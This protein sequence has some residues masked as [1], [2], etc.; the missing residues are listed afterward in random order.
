MYVAYVYQRERETK[1]Q[2]SRDKKRFKKRERQ[3][4]MYCITH[5]KNDKQSNHR[6]LAIGIP[7]EFDLIPLLRSAFGSVLYTLLPTWPPLSGSPERQVVLFPRRQLPWWHTS[8]GV[9]CPHTRTYTQTAATLLTCFLCVFLPDRR[10]RARK[11]TVSSGHVA[12]LQAGRCLAHEI[13]HVKTDMTG[14]EFAITGFL[15]L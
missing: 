8:E 1:K 14:Y 3:M 15:Q 9:A 5:T 2:R 11:C 12:S 7:K 6:L 4:A 10:C 13:S